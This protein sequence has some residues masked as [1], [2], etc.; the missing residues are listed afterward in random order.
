MSLTLFDLP[1]TVV[2]GH[3]SVSYFNKIITDDIVKILNST[4]NVTIFLPVDSAWDSLHPIERL[5]LE[6]EFATDDLLRILE[7]HAVVS[8]G[9]KWSEHFDPGINCESRTPSFT[10]LDLTSNSDHN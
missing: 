1:A 8:K 10:A 6:S 4:A 9:V 3:G 7:M 5:Y 2:S